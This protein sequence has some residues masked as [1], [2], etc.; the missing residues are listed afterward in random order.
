MGRVYTAKPRKSIASEC[1]QRVSFNFLKRFIRLYAGD[2]PASAVVDLMR[3]KPLTMDGNEDYLCFETRSLPTL[4]ERLV[5][6]RK[7]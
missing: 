1:G 7:N 3:R 6:R 5:G 4:F 2:T